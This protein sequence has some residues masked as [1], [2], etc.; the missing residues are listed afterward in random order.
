MRSLADQAQKRPLLLGLALIA[1]GNLPLFTTWMSVRWDT[2]DEMWTYFRWMGSALRQGYFPDFFPNIVA[3]YPLGANMQAGVYNVV[4]LAFSAMFADSLWSINLLYVLTQGAIFCLTWA[5]AG[6]CGLRPISRLYFGLAMTISGFVVGHA[7]HLSYLATAC[8]LLSCLLGLRWLMLG[9]RAGAFWA[10]SL[11]TYHMLTAGYPANSLFGVQCLAVYW[12]YLLVT[13]PSVRR[14][15]WLAPVASLSGLAIS[16]PAI[17]HLLHQ[18]GNSDRGEGVSIDSIS[19]GSMPAYSLLNY[20]LPWWPMRYSEPTMERF[21]LLWLSVPLTGYALW[22]AIARGHER[23]LVLSL[24]FL[25]IVLIVLALGAN[26]PLPIR[27]WLAEHSFLYRTGRFPSGE[28]RGIALFLL[29]WISAIGLNRYIADRPQHVRIIVRVLV[30]EF[31]L[32]LYA[33]AG[34]RWGTVPREQ[35]GTLPLIQASFGE[36]SQSLIDAPR[37]CTPVVNASAW[38]WPAIRFQLERLAPA[39]FSVHG[40]TNLKDRVWLKEQESA[41]SILCGPSRLWRATDRLAQ[42]YT[43]Q[44]YT[45][46][47]I[48][49]VVAGPP[50][51]EPLALIWADYTDGLWR[52]KI[53]GEIRPFETAPARLRG[54]QARPGDQVEMTYLGP[55][56]G[57]WRR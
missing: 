19:G 3:G 48:R 17:L 49:F 40:Y 39:G 34:T 35:Q 43:L 22:L 15:W 29:A 42:P 18:L 25:A 14:S 31:V 1:L 38:A 9:R 45:P 30:L 13:C 10:I 12:V 41:S 47:H 6:T 37:D 24:F 4:Y 26:S 52:L 55:L 2:R 53:N 28:H 32:G 8:G 21:H 56:S 7:S 57:L 33:L 5:I 11:G 50:G 23:R 16:A 46:G 54:F 44:R 36:L 27:I 51:V 20:L